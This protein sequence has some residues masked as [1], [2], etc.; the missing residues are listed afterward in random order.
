MLLERQSQRN[1][2][3]GNLRCVKKR[4]KFNLSISEAAVFMGKS[5]VTLRSWESQGLVKFSRHGNDRR[6]TIED[7]RNL[8][9]VAMKNR[10]ITKERL[11]IIE[12]TLTM[13]EI[14]ENE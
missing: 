12:A 4:S 9:Q 7:M 3:N 8:S 10:R 1:W 14:I 11:K 5:P 2:H 6:F 13:M